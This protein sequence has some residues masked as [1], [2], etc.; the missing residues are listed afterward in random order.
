VG[1][2]PSFDSFDLGFKCGQLVFANVATPTE[3]QIE[4]QDFGDEPIAATKEHNWLIIWD[5][6]A[7]NFLDGPVNIVFAGNLPHRLPP[8]AWVGYEVILLTPA[9]QD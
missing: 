9:G 2:L 7:I 5:L 6:G 8:T 4:I 3:K 1:C